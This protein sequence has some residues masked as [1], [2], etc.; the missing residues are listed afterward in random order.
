MPENEAKAHPRLTGIDWLRGLVMVLMLIDHTRDYVHCESAWHSPTDLSVISSATFLTRWMTHLC[1]P[2]F[3]LLAGVSIALQLEAGKSMA[4]VRRFLWTR[5]LWLVVLEFTLVRFAT[6]FKFNLWTNLGQVQVIWVLGISMVLMA[7]V[8]PLPR[9]WIAAFGLL[10]V[11]GHNLLDPISA[12][13]W[14][15]PGTPFPGMWDGLWSL[16][17]QQNFITPFGGQGPRLHITYPL[18]PWPGVM[19]LGYGLGSLFSQPSMDRRRHL[20][21]LG[22]AYVTSFVLLRAF[23]HFGDV[24]HWTTQGTVLRTVLSFLNTTKYPP[25]LLYLLMTLGPG[26]L[27]LAW[28]EG[29]SDNRLDRALVTFGRVPLFFYVLQWFVAHGMGVLFEA[30][31]GR[32]WRFMLQ[33]QGEPARDIGFRLGYVYLAWVIGLLLLYPL[34]RWFAGIKARHKAWWLSYL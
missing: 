3:V 24:A 9:R 26:L 25:S 4:E 1:A 10:L 27:L 6:I 22:L 15:G 13:V 23:N 28:R 14:Q 7:A 33:F 30:L 19:A 31:A 2:V 21:R 16:L 18:L 11:A 17:H 29:H 12:P 20:A 5:G 32:D 34:C 8:L